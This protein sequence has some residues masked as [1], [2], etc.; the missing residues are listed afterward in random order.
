MPDRQLM[1]QKAIA[2][3]L[4]QTDRVIFAV[5]RAHEEEFGASELLRKIVPGCEVIVLEDVTRGQA[6]TVC[7]MLAESKVEGGFLV[8]DADSYFVPDE[9]YDPRR[10]YVSVCSA[11]EVQKVKMYNKSFAVINEQGYIVGMVEKEITSEYFS[12]GGYFFA[13]P[14]LFTATFTQYDRLQAGG[15]FYLSQIIDLMIENGHIFHPMP[16]SHYEDWGTHEDWIV[17]RRRFGTYFFDI[18]GVLYENGNQYWA[19]RWG[20]TAVFPEVREKIKALYE[21]GNYIFLVTTR[22]EEFRALTEAQLQRD[23]VHYHQLAMGVHHGQ[24]VLI[25]DFGPTN[26]YPSAVAVNTLRNSQDF[27]DKL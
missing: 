21:A 2:P 10:N 12:C 22:P 20:E 1:F 11:R 27:L 24:R 6:E 17:Y 23:E 16:C 7:Q 26:P 14:T 8:K 13:D 9:A 18:D 5:I 19:P 3:L 25:N 4:S 15:E